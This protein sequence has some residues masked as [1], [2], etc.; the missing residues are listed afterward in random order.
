MQNKITFNIYIVIFGI[1]TNFLSF[2]LE[3]FDNKQPT[4][5]I[6]G[7]NRNIGLEFVKQYSEKNWNIIATTRQPETSL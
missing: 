6:T 2:Q 1:L 3:A 7:S 4:L 5:L